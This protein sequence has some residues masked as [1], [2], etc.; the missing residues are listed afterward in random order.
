MPFTFTRLDIPDVIL[1][2][3]RCFR[4]ERG[5]F[6]ETYKHS[7]FIE[8]GIS[9]PFVQTNH[10]HSMR[11]V[12]RGLH[13]QAPPMAQGKLVGAIHGRI[14]DV[15]VDLRKGSPTYGQWVGETLAGDAPRY[16][17]I[18]PG[19]AHGF[20]VLSATADLVYQVTAEYAAAHDRGILWND[21]EIGID[22]PLEGAPLLSPKD[23]AQPRLAEAETPFVYDHQDYPG[24]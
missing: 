20:C 3:P 10:S 21:P 19:F 18:P 14:F 6:L 11:G 2:E 4:D 23:E 16:L 5:F 24:R 12:L 22:W 13:Y 8:G 7:A 17:Y 15:G 1:V 9:E